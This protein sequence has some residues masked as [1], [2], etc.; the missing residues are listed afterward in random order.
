MSIHEVPSRLVYE[1]R[2]S[3]MATKKIRGVQIESLGLV[4]SVPSDSQHQAKM[5][6]GKNEVHMDTKRAFTSVWATL[7]V[8]IAACTLFTGSAAAKDP[9]FTDLRP[10]RIQRPVTSR[11]SVKRP[12]RAGAIGVAVKRP[13]T[14]VSIR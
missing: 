14:A 10:P 6:P 1:S 2:I 5:T 12:R 3:E 7:G 4:V 11:R 8:S 13:L 9:Q